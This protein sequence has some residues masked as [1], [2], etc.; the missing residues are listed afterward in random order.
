MR[1]ILMLCVALFLI[2]SARAETAPPHLPQYGQVN[3]WLGAQRFCRQY[4]REC[5]VRKREPLVV[6][7]PE[8]LVELD[9]V[10]RLVNHSVKYVPDNQQHGVE[11]WWTYPKNGKGDCEDY[12]LRKRRILQLKG[13]PKSSLLIAVAINTKGTGHAVL[14]IRTT[15]GDFVLDDGRDVIQLWHES[16]YH[17]VMRESEED[18]KQWYSAVPL[19]LQDE[20][21]LK[22]YTGK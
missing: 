7:T 10:N 20:V 18:P 1:F 19:P 2:E 22:L 13:W 6:L 17:F 14:L 15:S 4:A 3:A 9:E 21:I 11:D 12:V 8:R 5:M 16:P